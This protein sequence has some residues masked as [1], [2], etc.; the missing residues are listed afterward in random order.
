MSEPI[1]IDIQ[2]GFN[3]ARHEVVRV[4]HLPYG[5]VEVVFVASGRTVVMRTDESK[6]LAQALLDGGDGDE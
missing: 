6:A 3:G 4:R 5:R 1:L 2:P